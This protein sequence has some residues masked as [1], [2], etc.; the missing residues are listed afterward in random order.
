[1]GLDVLQDVSD[2]L[3]GPAKVAVNLAQRIVTIAE[4]SRSNTTIEVT[5]HSYCAEHRV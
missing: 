2:L 1:M 3:P 5:D 4:V